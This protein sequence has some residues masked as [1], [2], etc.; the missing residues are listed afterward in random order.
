MSVVEE[1]ARV[2]P[3]VERARILWELAWREK[4][5]RLSERDPC[6]LI[7]QMTAFD[8]RDAV[9]FPLSLEGG[10]EWQK[11]LVE[12]FH[13][14]KRCV[15]LKARQLGVTWVAAA[16][17]VWTLLFRPGSLV[18]VYR[19]KE[20]EA[21]ELVR[22]IWTL[23]KSLPSYLWNRAEV[24]APARDV[25][26][27]TVI[28]LTF[29]DGR[30]SRVSGMTSTGGAGHGRTAA[31]V[32]GDE[33]SRID[34]ASEIMKAVSAVVGQSGHVILVSTANGRYNEQTFSGNHFHYI[35]SHA[36]DAGFERRFLSWRN[37][38]DRDDDWYVNSPETRSL[39]EHERM[40][41]YPSNPEEAFTMSQRAYF[42]KASL[43]WYARDR[44]MDPVL[45]GKFEETRAGTAR[46]V[47]E[48][49][50]WVNVYARPQ[51]GHRYAIGADTATGKGMDFSA[52]YVIDLSNQELVAEVHGKMDADLY[53]E[54]LH[55]LGRWFNT[56]RVG[57]ES[58]GGYGEPVIISLRD[59]KRGRP[60]YSN[61]YRH[62]QF[63]RADLQQHAPY[64]FPMNTKT[65]PLVL[66]DMSAA[67]R[68]QSLPWMTRLLWD[69]CSSF[70]YAD[71]APS[72]RAEEGANDDCVMAC[73]VALELY[74]QFGEHADDVRKK[75]GKPAGYQPAYPWQRAA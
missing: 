40:E 75:R 33:W 35:W 53:A 3:G 37:H 47:E 19:Q 66:K 42:D 2:D 36:D 11:D 63:S 20:D 59:G 45:T 1:S 54:Q 21:K 55:Y 28:E 31:L 49:R 30:V 68:E 22:R 56:A 57:V 5:R 12:W 72:P 60:A 13:T 29:P 43:L 39:L 73:A 46:F 24:T 6:E 14:C 58:A 10:W 69:E 51:S 4:Q 62:R 74:R 9:E 48:K 15:V 61:L 26:P 8:E 38:P 70:V 64:G 71:A 17:A 44:I 34:R 52:A 67:I 25:L 23:L 16:Y 50:G 7:R 32:I 18:L 27:S 65:R 41:Q